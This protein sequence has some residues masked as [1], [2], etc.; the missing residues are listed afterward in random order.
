MTVTPSFAISDAP[1]KPVKLEGGR[2]TVTVKV[3]NTA[4]QAI[5]G[6]VLVKPQAPATL[7]WFAIA[8]EATRSYPPGGTQDVGV[9]I[10]PPAGTTPASYAVRIDAKNEVLSDEDYTDGPLVQ[11][12]VPEPR[13]PVPW[14]RKYWWVWAIALAI[15]V[16]A[17]VA[18]VVT[19]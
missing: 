17:I 19:S 9:E 16:L 3:T 13:P 12:V 5:T 15:V 6:T 18:I 4:T 10:A 14:W 11:F 8:G 7:A 2:A 1:T